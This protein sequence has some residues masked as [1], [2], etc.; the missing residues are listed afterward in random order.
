MARAYSQDLR[1]RLIAAVAAGMSCRAAAFRFGVSATTAVNWR[2]RWLAQ[3]N[4]EAKPMGGATRTRIKG[5]DATWLLKQVADEDDLTLHMMQARLKAERK[6]S[7]AIGSIWRF[8]DANRITLKK[9]SG[10]RRTGSGG[11]RRSPG[12]VDREAATA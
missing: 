2:Q 1:D 5:A 9:N 6:L 11:R 8:L 4:A 12:E 3:G 10:T 7:A